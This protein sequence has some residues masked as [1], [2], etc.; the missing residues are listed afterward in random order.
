MLLECMSN[1]VGNEMYD[2]PEKSVLDEALFAEVIT[3][4]IRLLADSTAELIVVSSVYDAKE[5]Y[6]E[7]T[8]KYINDLSEGEYE[9]R[10]IVLGGYSL[11]GLFALWAGTKN[12]NY[13]G[14][15]A[16]SP[17]VWF[18]GFTEYLKEHSAMADTVYLSLGDKESKT[19]N[20][21]LATT[22]A[23]IEK[24]RDILL[25]Q[26]VNCVLEWNEGNHFKEPEKRMAK[27]FAWALK[28]MA[29]K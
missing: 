22:D 16:A 8:L 3:R 2:N 10:K 12:G 9:G 14:I 29:G 28:E 11:A 13:S 15:V 23:C 20:A 1:L 5:E 24:T 25:G 6:S 26:G 19:K 18:P 17:S 21:V 4:D 27:G 7:E